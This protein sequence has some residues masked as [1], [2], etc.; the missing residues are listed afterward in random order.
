MK[1]KTLTF[2]K[3]T[4][5]LRFFLLIAVFLVSFYYSSGLILF[6]S[7]VNRSFS[8]VELIAVTVILTV[9]TSLYFYIE[10]REKGLV[11]NYYL[12]GA[13]GLLFIVNTITTFFFKSP[14]EFDYVSPL[15]DPIHGTFTINIYDKVQYVFRFIG[16]LLVS[17]LTIVVMPQKI[18]TDK[19][20]KRIALLYVGVVL[21]LIIISYIT[22]FNDYVSFFNK[23]SESID[24]DSFAIAPL[25]LHKNTYGYLIVLAIFSTLLVHLNDKKWYW[26]VLVGYLY[27]N[28]LFSLCKAGIVIATFGVLA[29]LISRFFLT[30]KE[31]KKMNYIVLAAFLGFALILFSLYLLGNRLGD[32]NLLHKISKGINNIFT[33]RSSTITTR[34]YIWDNVNS[35]ISSTSIVFG[36]GYGLFGDLL[37]AYNMSSD[38][39][40]WINNTHQAH[41]A[42]LQYL[43]NGGIIT[44]LIAL[45]VIGIYV[46]AIIKIM[47]NH[48]SL[49]I[50]SLI[51]LV[52]S[53]AYSLVENYPLFLG[54]T[55]EMMYLNVLLFVPVMQKFIRENKFIKVNDEDEKVEV[56]QV[57]RKSIY[58]FIAPIVGCISGIGIALAIKVHLLFLLFLT[59]I[60][61]YYVIMLILNKKNW[62]LIKKQSALL[63]AT[64]LISFIGCF[65]LINSMIFAIAYAIAWTLIILFIA[66]SLPCLSKIYYTEPLMNRL[67]NL[68]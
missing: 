63:F 42:W 8:L 36:C 65:V 10:Y 61:I 2:S 15:G 52:S 1:L 32:S 60:I 56:G 29:Y 30:Y 64:L 54:S 27:L 35:I 3:R 46:Y 9:I 62:A 14:H 22:K 44:L 55:T 12:L 20:I 53:I 68:I 5:F 47:K 28:L 31:H 7:P 24:D 57:E 25:G 40:K 66:I 18:K 21:I 50:W 37:H 34:T 39:T 16:I 6:D 23:F 13:L 67:D 51:L 48:K 17:Y 49:A 38:V 41:N 43:G 26:L 33:E 59:T 4:A 58:T 19:G 11:H 45:A